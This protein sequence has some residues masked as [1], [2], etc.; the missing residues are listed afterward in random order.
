MKLVLYPSYVFFKSISFDEEKRIQDKYSLYSPSYW[1]SPFFK[2]H[3]QYHDFLKQ[4]ENGMF[5]GSKEEMEKTRQQLSKRRMWDGKVSF[6]NKNKKTL[7]IGFLDEIRAE[8][9]IDEIT[10]S[11]NLN[12]DYDYD[13]EINKYIKKK[14]GVKELEYRSFQLD[15]IATAMTKKLGIFN[16]AVNSGKTLIF[17]LFSMIYRKNTVLILVHRKEILNQIVDSFKTLVN[18]KDVGIIA[19]DELKLS[20]GITVGMVQTVNNRLP[21]IK[22]WFDKVNVLMIDEA[23]HASSSGY[24]NL[25]RKS[26][27]AIRFGFS[28]TVPDEEVSRM[29]VQQFLG[30]VIG[31]IDSK[32]LIDMGISAPP[33]IKIVK[34]E[35]VD[36]DSYRESIRLNVKY[37]VDKIC[38]IVNIIKSLEG[39]KVLVITDV[40]SMGRIVSNVLKVLGIKN[41][42]FYSGIE[43][44]AGALATFISGRI[45]LII[46][47]TIM[48]EGVDISDIDAVLLAYPRKNYRQTFQRIGRGMRMAEGKTHVDVFDFLDEDDTYLLRHFKK[49]LKYYK[50]E[51]FEFE[52]TPDDT[53]SNI[54]DKLRAVVS[55]E[56][57]IEVATNEDRD[58][59]EADEDD[60]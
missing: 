12:I 1:F 13:F 6:Y 43:D 42:L 23:H 17:I 21:E 36:I 24:S 31:H 22:E 60:S 9:L 4:V 38:K 49:R 15:S 37:N 41:I 16:M 26:R 3:K 11:R 35:S 28:G 55:R 50:D 54:D 34:T 59:E 32:T 20:D 53:Y 18:Y 51:Q 48:D 40:L 46:A 30:P 27:A 44:R 45:K 52:F 25:L 14:T 19:A 2:N 58:N 33:K 29:K 8:Y 47:T 39:K 5:M 57:D 56:I 10:E 7:P